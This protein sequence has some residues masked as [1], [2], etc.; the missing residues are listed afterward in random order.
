MRL[1]SAVIWLVA[2]TAAPTDGLPSGDTAPSR[3]TSTT[4]DT[5]VETTRAAILGAFQ[6]TLAYLRAGT[7]GEPVPELRVQLTE[8]GTREV[9]VE[10]SY[11][12]PGVL[13]GPASV[14][15]PAGELSAP[16]ELEAVMAS[17]TPARVVATLREAVAVADVRVYDDADARALAGVGPDPLYVGVGLAGALEVTLDLPAPSS[18]ATLSVAVDPAD[19]LAAASVEVPADSLTATIPAIGSTPGEGTITVSLGASSVQIDAVVIDNPGLWISEVFGNPAG[20]DDSLEWVKLW[21]HTGAA[22]DLSGYALG[23][24]GADYTYGT[25]QLSGT[26]EPL[27]CVLIGGPVSSA[28]NGDPVLGLAADFDPDIQNGGSVADGVALFD[29][30]AANLTSTTVPVD[31]VLYGAANTSGLLGPDGTPS[32]V[33]AKDVPQGRSLHLEPGA[34]PGPAVSLVIGVRA[35]EPSLMVTARR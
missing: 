8:P 19:L 5:S 20:P 17:A 22:V 11:D 26:V 7:Q 27:G 29:V 13:T 15:V 16:V 4:G 6:P 12:T 21:N 24:G 1:A 23:W 10:L 14:V 32:V 30:L 9:V 33:H 34:Q 3:S 18:G 25:L 2:C 35:A 31:A 28:D